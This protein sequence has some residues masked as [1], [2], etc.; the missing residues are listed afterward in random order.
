[1]HKKVK[2]W[3]WRIYKAELTQQ[4]FCERFDIPPSQLSD[5]LNGRKEPKQSSIDK[6]ELHLKS[7]G[8]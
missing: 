3:K 2:N 8:V 5:W 6:V 4:K 1:M 7:L